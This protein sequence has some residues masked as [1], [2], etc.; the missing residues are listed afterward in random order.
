MRQRRMRQEASRGGLPP[1]EDEAQAGD[2]DGNPQADAVRDWGEER[3]KAGERKN[4]VAD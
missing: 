4:A 3:R 2:G 1:D